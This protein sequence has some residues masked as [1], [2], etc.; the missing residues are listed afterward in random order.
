MVSVGVDITSCL[1]H[2]QSVPIMSVHARIINVGTEREHGHM[3]QQQSSEAP[4]MDAANRDAAA[5]AAGHRVIK[6]SF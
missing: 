6:T 3:M 2:Q 4:L 1:K 5:E